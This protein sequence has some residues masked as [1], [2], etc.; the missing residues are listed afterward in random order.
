MEPIY[1]F[2]YKYQIILLKF[3]GGKEKNLL[4]AEFSLDTDIYCK[5]K[6]EKESLNADIRVSYSGLLDEC[7]REWII[8]AK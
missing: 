5:I 3:E 2:E 8:L 1:Y 4:Y 6:R 7:P